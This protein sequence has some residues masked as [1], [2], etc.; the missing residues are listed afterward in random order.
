MK[1]LNLNINP[2]YL[3]ESFKDSL[4]WSI[5]S[6]SKM[7]ELL[8]MQL[9]RKGRVELTGQ[10]VTLDGQEYGVIKRWN[11]KSPSRNSYERDSYNDLGLNQF[12]VGQDPYKAYDG[13]PKDG[14][15]H[16]DCYIVPKSLSKLSGGVFDS[17]ESDLFKDIALSVA[18]S[19]WMWET[20]R[21]F[22]NGE[23]L[24]T[25][26]YV[27]E[28]S[29]YGDKE[30]VS[31]TKEVVEDKVFA[32]VEKV[33]GS[34]ENIPMVQ[35]GGAYPEIIYKEVLEQISWEEG[36]EHPSVRTYTRGY[37]PI[38]KYIEKFGKPLHSVESSSSLAFFGSISGRIYVFPKGITL[39][40]APPTYVKAG[41][42]TSGVRQFLPLINLKSGRTM[43]TQVT[44]IDY[45]DELFELYVHEDSEWWE[46]ILQLGMLIGMALLAYYMSLV[47]C[48][49]TP[50]AAI[51]AM[52]SVFSSIGAMSGNEIFKIVSNI[53]GIVSMASNMHGAIIGEAAKKLGKEIVDTTIKEAIKELSTKTIAKMSFEMFMS[54]FSLYQTISAPKPP[55]MLNE[56]SNEDENKE[57]LDIS[58]SFYDD[59][60][61]V[62]DIMKIAIQHEEIMKI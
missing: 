51:G 53:L 26:H 38:D 35:V 58:W 49:S 40:L 24:Y 42:F 4:F 52:A 2:N 6:Y 41:I 25:Y 8:H 17:K 12:F 15:Y 62:D 46:P 9:W 30:V 50:V 37:V 59:R 5:I 29:Y 14:I 47:V 7:Y 55:E 1:N 44:F 48:M 22:E 32:V 61:E 39:F 43:L 23:Y 10:R 28:Y 19:G 57:G 60:V 11:I 27:N 21:T 31:V 16:D 45:W 33:D 54:V 34:K 3:Y 18:M 20:S 56:A 13:D 36:G